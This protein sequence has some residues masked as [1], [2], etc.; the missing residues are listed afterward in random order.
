LQGQG[1]TVK[2][3]SV[4]IQGNK[5]VRLRVGPYRDK[6]AASKA[7]ANLQKELS[8]QGVVLAYP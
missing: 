4:T 8:I 7:Q 3:E 1:Y 5:A 6:T 2:S